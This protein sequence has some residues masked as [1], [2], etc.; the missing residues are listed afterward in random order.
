MEKAL[1]MSRQ[2]FGPQESG[3]VDLQG[4]TTTANRDDAQQNH[5][6]PNQWS[7]TLTNQ[8]ARST[9]SVTEMFPE[10]D[11]KQRRHHDQVPRFL[12]PLS[13]A[14]YLPNLL[15]IGY[16]IPLL[17]DLWLSAS[18]TVSEYGHNP[19][20]WRGAEIN[21]PKVIN[22]DNGSQ[23]GSGQP[24]DILLEYQ[25][26]M[27]FMDLSKRLYAS[28]QALATIVRATD[29]ASRPTLDTLIDQT[30]S[31]WEASAIRQANLDQRSA[32]SLLALHS[33]VASNHPDGVRTPDFWTL[34]L[35]VVIENDADGA[36]VSLGETV[37]R[38]L[39]NSEA[40]ENS[41]DDFHDTYLERCADVLVMRVSQANA[42]RSSL[43]LIIPTEFHVDRY[44]KGNI[45]STRTLRREMATLRARISKS[46]Q[47]IAR[48]ETFRHPDT[49][50]VIDASDIFE[51]VLRH[52]NGKNRIAIL[53]ERESRGVE[54]DLPEIP[55]EYAAISEKLQGLCGDIEAKLAGS[56]LRPITFFS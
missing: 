11:I 53:E 19:E 41:A 56:L 4:R 51:H 2:A 5:Y 17:R 55:P 34:P 1:A 10:V 9:Q 46:E 25:R 20:W 48:L 16:S 27:A 45:E 54:V 38:A 47:I 28:P 7:M 3:V 33:V 12:R 49:P 15:T 30:L 26:L 52:Y 39:W 23:A 37:D 36:S 40:L 18:S 22:M 50:Q 35:T 29:P 43:G 8:P 21:V 6:D 32:D 31:S 14:D 42:G 44:L 13:A 24:D